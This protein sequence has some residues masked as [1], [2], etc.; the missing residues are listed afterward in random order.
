MVDLCPRR[1]QGRFLV[2]APLIDLAGGEP[3]S[4]FAEAAIAAH[5]AAVAAV[6]AI[7]NEEE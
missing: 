5:L 1:S 2:P 7:T 3:L 6:S 4:A